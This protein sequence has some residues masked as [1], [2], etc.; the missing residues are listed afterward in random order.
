MRLISPSATLSLTCAPPRRHLSRQAGVVEPER[1]VR[2]EPSR[3]W[4]SLAGR[5]AA[6]AILD[7]AREPAALRFAQAQHARAAR[8][9]APPAPAAGRPRTRRLDAAALRSLERGRDR[10]RG[11]QLRLTALS[12]QGVLERGYSI[13]QRADGQVVTAPEQAAAGDLLRVTL[14]LVAVIGSSGRRRGKQD[15]AR[16]IS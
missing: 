7:K 10:F 5:A 2:R 6:R 14:L 13:V 9:A 4:A 15:G 1:G 12:P 3:N 8:P 11:A 16:A